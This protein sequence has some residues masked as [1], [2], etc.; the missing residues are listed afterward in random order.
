M[1]KVLVLRRRCWVTRVIPLADLQTNMC[2]DIRAEHRQIDES[3][4]VLIYEKVY[5][6]ARKWWF[7][8]S[9]VWL[10]VSVTFVCLPGCF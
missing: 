3:L 7:T 9:K 1:E 6:S 10:S 5:R 4:A 2:A 8:V